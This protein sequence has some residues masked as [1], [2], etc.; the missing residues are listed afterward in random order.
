MLCQCCEKEESVG[1]ACLPGIPMS[2]AMCARCVKSRRYPWWVVVANTVLVTP[3]AKDWREHAADWWKSAVLRN[4]ELHN[5][6]EE[7]FVA[8]VQSQ[9]DA[10]EEERKVQ[11]RG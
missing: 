2:V 1:V 4:L 8:E 7:D 6:S 9:L 5:K 10:D 3:V 11:W